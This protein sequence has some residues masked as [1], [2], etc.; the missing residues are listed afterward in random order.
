MLFKSLVTFACIASC[1][2]APLQDHKHH[3]HKEEKRAVTVVNTVYVTVGGAP[4]AT[5]TTNVLPDDVASTD[6]S[7]AP[8][9]SDD[10]SVGAAGAKGVTYSPYKVGS[11]KT[12]DE[13]ASEIAEL[14]GFDII[15][16]YAV[17][18]D[19]VG[20]VLRAK[21]KNQKIFAGIFDMGKIESDIQALAQA[22]K[23]NGSWD[24]IYTVS[25]GNE[26]VNNGQ[27]TPAQISEYVNRGRAALKAAGYNGP[28]VSVDTFI[29]VINN[30]A[31]CDYSDYMAVNAHAFFDGGIAAPGSGDWVLQQI[32]RV[33]TT[34][35][36][37]KVFITET[38]WPSKGEANNKAIPS[39]ENQAAAISS[40]KKVCGND[41]TLF[42]AFNDL[43]KAPGAF[44]AEQWW[45]I[46]N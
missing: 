12:S 45:G 37:K 34:C 30:P 11:C 32:Q 38:G 46:L 43:W 18:C 6:A 33:A 9:A 22:V 36:G 44:N 21:A 24:D 39:K 29:A 27:A 1:L 40:I 41:V 19:Q 35:P 5:P 14:S 3:D 7:T 8:Q 28:V 4:V 15:R 23:E 31:L 13:I 20:A 16:L 42:S 26:L 17:D 10:A 2:A 25:I